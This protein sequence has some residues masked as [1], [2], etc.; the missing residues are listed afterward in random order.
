MVVT[1]LSHT[2]FLILLINSYVYDPATDEWSTRTA[3][4]EARR[5]GSAAVVVSPDETKIYVSHGTIGGHE[6]DDHAEALP[7]LDVY[8]IATDTWTAL[9]DD[10]PHP[11]GTRQNP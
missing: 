7:Y 10:V 1:A 5:R 8:D 3:L 2:S 11:R 4:P 9:S 6:T